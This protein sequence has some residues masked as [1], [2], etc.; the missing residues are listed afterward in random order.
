M[1]PSAILRKNARFINRR[2]VFLKFD[3]LKY[4][5][6]KYRTFVFIVWKD[7]VWYFQKMNIA[8]YRPCLRFWQLKM[9]KC[10]GLFNKKVSSMHNATVDKDNVLEKPYVYVCIFNSYDF[11][12]F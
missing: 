6:Y 4:E 1:Y 10:S 3:I 5:K 8:Y 12:E 7:L 2:S 9:D 11:V